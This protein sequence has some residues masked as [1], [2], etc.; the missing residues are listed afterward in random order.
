M[1][2]RIGSDLHRAR[3]RREI[4]LGQVEAATRIR[5]RFL[6]AIE[7]EEWDALPG[8]VYTRGFIRTYA[9]Y[10][11]L[12]GD[13]LAEDYRRQV[14]G[15]A[16]RPPGEA[17][18]QAMGA[19]PAR[20]GRRRPGLGWLAIALVAAIAAIAVFAIPGG[21]SGEEGGGKLNSAGTRHGGGAGAPSP[22]PEPTTTT[23]KPRGVSISLVADAEVWVC[24]LAGDGRRLVDGQILQA[25]SEAGSFRSGSFTVSFG[26]GEVTMTIDGKRTEIPPTSS[27]VGYAIDSAGRLTELSEAERPTCE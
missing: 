19:A 14:E 21:K 4:D 17:P 26:N 12:D 8:G 18:V 6:I 16:G 15:G 10:L 9:S 23:A 25:G 11:G 3:T 7:N 1:A 24:V 22:K 20:R 27:P 5:A 2:S 13:R